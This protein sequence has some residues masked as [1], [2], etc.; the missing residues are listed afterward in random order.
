MTDRQANKDAHALAIGRIVMAWNELQ[1]T[2]GE[3]F[4]GLFDD[5][6]WTSALSA[7]HALESDRAQRQM[8]RA[9]AED[10][11]QQDGKGLSEL[12]WLIGQ[13]DQMI[14]QQRNIGIH[15]P[16]MSYTNL[17]GVHSIMPFAM[18]GNRKAMALVDVNILL[19]YA[20]YEQQIRKLLTFAIAIQFNL[21]MDEDHP[22]TWPERPKL[23]SR[24]PRQES[25]DE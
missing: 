5:E 22:A 19:E 4:A 8:L 15:A 18:F 21:S 12:K 23:T 25:K 3:T 7:W 6:S 14:S 16:L 17:D 9:V 11:L 1:E 10:R 24:A 2:L 13:I 20:H